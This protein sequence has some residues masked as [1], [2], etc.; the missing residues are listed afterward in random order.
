MTAQVMCEG[1][2][3]DRLIRRA[4]QTCDELAFKVIRNLAQQ[5]SLAVRRRFG[6]YI[7]QLVLLLKVRGYNTKAVLLS[8]PRPIHFMFPHFN[9]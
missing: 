7:E 2:R 4:F 9:A 6:P 1:D 8:K 5:E 3:F